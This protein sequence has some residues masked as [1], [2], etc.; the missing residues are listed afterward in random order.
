[1]ILT[2]RSMIGGAAVLGAGGLA[3]ASLSLLRGSGAAQDAPG[4]DQVLHDTDGPVLGNP[5]G[6]VT[7]VEYFDYQ[8][9]YCKAN[10]PVLRDLVAKDGQL[11]LLMKD[12][13]I[14]GG[15]SVRASQLAL[16]AV[17]PGRY[18][19]A[20]DALMA[21]PGKLTDALIDETLAAA[22]VDPAA[23]GEAY[24]ANRDRWDG[25]MTR[26]AQQAAALNLQG[27]PAFIIGPR[28]YPG[29]LDANALSAAVARARAA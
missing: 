10:H 1:M 23:M 9:P 26:N 19:A 29:A 27:T 14:F 15:A 4:L 17:G 6:D 28:L 20:H 3:A 21:T 13:P 16:G 7:I 5:E 18:E 25:F 22:G 11:R 12:W 8:C 2:R 24:R